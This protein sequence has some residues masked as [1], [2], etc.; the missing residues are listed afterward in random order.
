LEAGAGTAF[1]VAADAGG[2]ANS[3]VELLENQQARLQL[4][5]SALRFAESWNRQCRLALEDSVVGDLAAFQ[6]NTRS[7]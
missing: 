7:K 6:A 2:L 5:E 1:R 3:C 4:S